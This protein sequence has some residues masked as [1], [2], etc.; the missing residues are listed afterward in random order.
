MYEYFLSMVDVGLSR[1]TMTA[2]M[3]LAGVDLAF[4]AVSDYWWQSEMLVENTKRIADD[5][6]S[7]GEGAVTVFV[8]RR[9]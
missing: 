7:V 6:F 2:A 5:W 1:D 8:F 3:D 4:F 9:E